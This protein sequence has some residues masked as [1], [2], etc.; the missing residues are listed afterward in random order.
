M[1]LIS[2]ND[3]VPMTNHGASPFR[4]PCDF[5]F[6]LNA[7]LDAD[8]EPATVV[9]A[10]VAALLGV[11]QI[12]WAWIGKVDDEGRLVAAADG[13]HCPPQYNELAHRASRMG[14][15]QTAFL[16][17]ALPLA[18]RSGNHGVLVVQANHP[19]FLGGAWSLATLSHVAR[20]LG[21]ALES[22]EQS[23][24]LQRTQRL[25]QT[26]FTGV[27]QLLAARTP[28][29][30][31][32][33]LC[34]T[35][36]DSGLFVSAGVGIVGAGGA[37]RHIAVC[38]R[39][40]V[41]ALRAASLVYLKGQ[42]RRPLTFDAWETGK[43][44]VANTYFSN[45]RFAPAYPLAEKLG[46]KAIA[47]LIVHRGGAPWGI[48]SVSAAAENYFD[49]RLI[50][51]LERMSSMVGHVLDEF[52]LKAALWA[53]RET[54][55]RIARQ[56][57]L[58]A[59]PNRLAY[60]EQLRAR[61]KKAAR[62]ETGLV[63]AM[64]DLNGFKQVNDLWGHAAGD[65]ILRV[66]G[67]RIRAVLRDSD[68]VGRLGGDEF[69]LILD[70]LPCAPNEPNDELQKF[71]DR[72]Q[73]S[74]SA[75]VVLPNGLSSR[76]SFCAGFAAFAPETPDADVLL[77]RADRALYD[78]KAEAARNGRF[79][80]VYRDQ[81]IGR[82]WPMDIWS[83]LQKGALYP[84]FQP[85]L[86]LETGQINT[87]E[88]LARLNDGEEIIPP[89]RF[90]P[91][92][93][94]EE[95][96]LLFRKMLDAS[97]KQVAILA[98]EGHE[99]SVSVNLDGEV[100]LQERTL[101]LIRKMLASHGVAPAL[102]VL[103]ILET[104]EFF[105]LQNA[106][107]QITALQALGV[108]IALDDVGAGHSSLLKVKDLPL[109]IVKLDRAFVARLTEQ[110]DDLVFIATLQTL[111]ATL[112][113]KLI[114]EGAEDDVVLG[115]LRIVG[116]RHVQG[117][118]IA[119]PMDGPA[120]AKW[121]QDYRPR[122]IAQAPASL[123]GAYALHAKWLRALE[124]CQMHEATLLSL[125]HSD[126][127]CLNAYF[128]EAGVP[129]EPVRQAYE[130][131]KTLMKMDVVDLPSILQA[132]LAFRHHMIAALAPRRGSANTQTGRRAKDARSYRR[133]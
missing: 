38:A 121:L 17:A 47:A 15:P 39:R 63:V 92:M 55:R 24:V 127:F 37:H 76:V 41:Q 118:A 112:G 58:T 8:E 61:L 70:G 2:T 114:V 96:S 85:V 13:S 40:N 35:L 27:D 78:A 94:P 23:A 129:H 50:A 90:L 54:Q 73:E 16:A 32:R 103:E 123:L 68:V 4:N 81:T 88:A 99:I 53:E 1:S 74:V 91:H 124:F 9:Q 108:Q 60:H 98:S 130:R 75:P 31:L 86:D 110:P 106:R 89:A 43:T 34:K 20:L 113:M 49:D 115:A 21:G 79:W 131:L 71:C 10:V 44:V 132:S 19:G 65:H 102:L 22:R 36:V 3:A 6:G 125:L 111:T 7:I 29:Q 119:R 122:A 83:M 97:L 14:V 95:R 87:M 64:L 62:A 107:A 117:F 80:R 5:I 93:T 120:L 72:L 101:P 59:L 116:V 12:A 25:Y 33:L 18:G 67:L 100:L 126:L 52:D 105:S 57:M 26:L 69:A 46:F 11:P 77:R 51:L 48:L 109:D 45:P 28:G 66:V 56:D 42:E 82:T 104:H 30:A 84:D 128:A 133:A